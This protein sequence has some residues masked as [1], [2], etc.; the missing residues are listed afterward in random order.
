MSAAIH[1]TSA[2]AAQHWRAPD[3]VRALAVICVMPA[4]PALNSDTLGEVALLLDT[5]DLILQTAAQLQLQNTDL[6]GHE[7]PGKP[8]SQQM[9]NQPD[10]HSCKASS[11][12][13]YTS[14][15]VPSA[16]AAVGAKLLGNAKQLGV[17]TTDNAATN[18]ASAA[19][20]AA[21]CLVDALL[22]G[23]RA[24]VAG[25]GS[26]DCTAD[27][28]KLITSF[29]I[30]RCVTLSCDWPP[31]ITI[32]AVEVGFWRQPDPVRRTSI[33]AVRPTAFTCIVNCCDSI[34]ASCGQA[35]QDWSGH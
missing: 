11:G 19:C 17:P 31:A 7:L 10:R 23:L 6:Q 18:S 35:S 20:S 29:V 27:S 5:L 22:W 12:P 28:S 16:A 25:A 24:L 14:P 3:K 33:P 15:C 26:H 21:D 32:A 34:L 8:S 1:H 4:A 13:T 9:P 2:A 30:D